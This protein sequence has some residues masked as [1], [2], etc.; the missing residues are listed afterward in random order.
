MKR[1]LAIRSSLVITY[2]LVACFSL[3]IVKL[4]AAFSWRPGGSSMQSWFNVSE[5]LCYLLALSVIGLFWKPRWVSLV[6]FFCLIGLVEWLIEMPTYF[7]SALYK[8]GLFE[9]S[10]LFYLIC[11]LAYVYC[12]V[13]SLMVFIKSFLKKP[14]LLPTSGSEI[15]YSSLLIAYLLSA[16][17][18]GYWATDA[19]DHASIHNLPLPGKWWYHIIQLASLLLI[20]NILFFIPKGKKIWLMVGFGCLLLLL[21]QCIDYLKLCYQLSEMRMTGMSITFAL[22][23]IVYLI[24]LVL[25]VVSYFRVF[26]WNKVKE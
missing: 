15:R 9:W 5:W 4:T 6:A 8:Y 10:Y 23:L 16:G 24:G 3:W 25:T 1:S 2:L 26:N 17:F 19:L 7:F 18:F 13:M 22:P 21:P 14:L 11:F 12:L 20:V